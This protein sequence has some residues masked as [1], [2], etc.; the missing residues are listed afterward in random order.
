MCY[1]TSTHQHL[2]ARRCQHKIIILM[3]TLFALHHTR[4]RPFVRVIFHCV[5]KT[6][7]E[8]DHNPEDGRANFAPRNVSLSAEFLP[9][10]NP[11]PTLP[12]LPPPLSPEPPLLLP[13]SRAPCQRVGVPQPAP[14]VRYGP[15]DGQ[16]YGSAPHRISHWG[17]RS[18]V[19]P[20]VREEPVEG[21]GRRQGRGG[22]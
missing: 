8:K 6:S 2:G 22:R 10:I 9:P 13:H 15:Q 20:L 4:E 1:I 12:S 7:L 17:P 5:G 18:C 3:H 21:D 16:S 11:A 19:V 14:D